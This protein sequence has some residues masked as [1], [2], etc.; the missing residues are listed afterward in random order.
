[1]SIVL[2]TPSEPIDVPSRDDDLRRR[3][4]RRVDGASLAVVRMVLGV[5]GVASALRLTSRGWVDSLLV[6][7]SNHLAY[8][9]MSWVP[10]PQRVGAYAL[11]AVVALSGVAVALGW[12]YRVAVVVFALAFTWLEF[13]EASMYLNHYWF[14]TLLSLSMCALPADAVWS[15]D[16]RRRRGSNDAAT[17]Q[18]SV[19]V[20]AVWLV[21]AQV[22]MVYLFAG[23][24]KLHGDWLVRGLPLAL[25]MPARSDHPLLGPIVDL[26]HAAVV[27]S[28][29]GA[30]FDC[31]IVVFLLWRRTRPVAWIVLVGFH[32]V[33]WML[34]PVIGVFP[35][36]MIAMSTVFFDPDW[37]RRVRARLRGPGTT[38]RHPAEPSRKTGHFDAEAAEP[39]R[40]TGHFDT[41]PAE[42]SRKTGHFDSG[43]G[44]IPDAR[45]A[46]EVARPVARWAL[47]AATL[48]LLVQVALPLRHLAYPG[49]HR[50]TGQGY[51]FGWN[52]MLVEKAGDL[53]FRVT[54][55]TTG[56]TVRDDASTLYTP[57]QW[58]VLVTDPELI[59]QAAHAVA[60]AHGPGAEVR[61]DAYVSLNGRPAERIV[62]PD[63][64]LA[65]EPWRLGPQPWILPVP[66]P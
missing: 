39:S 31:T 58:R 49:D 23:I 10:V 5:L 64:D 36:V 21:R 41:E 33:T 57:V 4:G 55:P 51:R 28:V 34:F 66:T 20:A 3:L 61:A 30:V 12:R 40:K 26:P 9:G 37:P 29:A 43:A 22:A 62:D 15:L 56:A 65:A 8:A 17:G 13:V 19:A 14:V 1:M 63:V 25:W 46:G 32:V 7:P 50:W 60:R 35:W 2:A 45:S 16:A 24:A 6:D 54:D 48:W 11:V 52:V 27:A 53:S 18:G 44:T 47:V 59:R 42:L 38:P